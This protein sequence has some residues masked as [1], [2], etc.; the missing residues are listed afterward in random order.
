MEAQ[1]VAVKTL[2]EYPNNARQGDVE[3]L[4]ESL[5]ANGQYR[6]IVVQKSTN[7]VLAGNHL[8]KAAQKLD[9]QNIDVVFVDV[10]DD[11]AT[12]IV[13]S[14]NRTAELGTYDERKLAELLATLD[15]FDGTGYTMNDLDDLI[16]TVEEADYAAMTDDEAYAL[17]QV[18]SPNNVG[19]LETI[20]ELRD[21]YIDRASR[22]VLFEFENK[23]YIWIVEALAQARE[24][25]GVKNNP[26]LLIELLSK[27]LGVKYQ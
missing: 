26:E 14:D 8:L 27:E 19:K 7:Y 11:A 12:R 20:D 25:F 3:A 6:P 24:K 18:A 17:P 23:Q 22:S 1:S 16:A 21:K 5:R 10:D 13:I 4:S 9:W 15:T 2:K